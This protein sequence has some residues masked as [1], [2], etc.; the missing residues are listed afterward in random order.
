MAN[1]S[2]PVAGVMTAITVT[3][4]TNL[5]ADLN[6]KLFKLVE[7]ELDL[8]EKNIN[9]AISTWKHKPDWIRKINIQGGGR[10]DEVSGSLYTTSTPFVWVMNGTRKGNV[11]FSKSFRPKTTA[12]KLGSGQGA[13]QVIRRG[14]PAPFKKIEGRDFQTILAQRRK[15]IFPKKVQRVLERQLKIRKKTQSV[16]VTYKV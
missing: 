6:Y 8:F 12:G 9:K 13:G 14:R 4:P 11:L 5:D 3:A 2:N 10:I 1:S 15:N 16:K 7:Q